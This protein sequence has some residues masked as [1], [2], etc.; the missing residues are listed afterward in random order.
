MKAYP[1]C[2]GCGKDNSAECL[3]EITDKPY[4]AYMCE[5]NNIYN[6]LIEVQGDE[7]LIIKPDHIKPVQVLNEY[8]I[9]NDYLWPIDNDV[10]VKP[11]RNTTS[12]ARL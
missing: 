10:P 8:G 3:K 12:Q 11:V 4:V 6:Q 7:C 1:N 5:C 9:Y 2:P